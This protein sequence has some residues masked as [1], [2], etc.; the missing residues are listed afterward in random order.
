MDTRLVQ[1]L[2][3]QGENYLIPF[4]WQYGQQEDE[5][6]HEIEKI[7]ETGIRSVCIESRTH[8]DF[9]GDGWWNDMDIIMDEAR[10]RNMRVW[11]LDD[12]RFPTGFAAGKIRDQFPE[13]RKWYLDQRHV[14][15]IGPMRGASVLVNTHLLDGE[16]LVGVVAARNGDKE[17][18][19]E[20]T[21]IN[22]TKNIRSGSLYWDI[23]EGCWRVF[24]LVM[25]R[26][27]GEVKTADYLNPIVPES[28]RVLIDTVYETHYAR[29]KEDFGNT[30]AGFF[31]D[32][33]RFGN[34]FAMDAS[35][36]R[37]LMVLPWRED[38]I[39]ILEKEFGTD[40][41]KYLPCLWYNAGDKTN[42]LR[43]LYMNTV[44]SLYSEHF[45]GQIGNWCRKHKVEYIGHVIEDNNAHAR[46]GA[47][48]GHFFRALWGQDMSGL[49]VVL[50]QIRP[51]FDY[52]FKNVS[53]VANGEFYHYGLAKMASSLGHIDPKKK[54]RTICEI[55]GAY[56]WYEGL[57]LMK[58]LTDHMLVRGVNYFVP[59]A[60]SSKEYP[61]SDCPPHFYANGNNP[62]FRYY[63]ILMSYTN[64]ICHLLNDGTHVAPVAVLYH[65]EAEWSGE[66][67]LFQKPVKEL[68]QHQIDC[69]IIPADIF[70][71][72][73]V[74]LNNEIYINKE[75]YKCLVIPYAESLPE[76]LLYRVHEMMEKGLPV[77]FID[78]LP[79][80][81]SEG[82]TNEE[83]LRSIAG[84]S[85]LEI[86][87]LDQLVD[88]IHSAGIS[89][90]K[91]NKFK[92]YLR[93][94]H[95]QRGEADLYMFFNEDPYGYIETD[96]EIPL[97]GLACEY[98]AFLNK[99]K[100]LQ[101]EKLDN[102][103][104]ISLNLAPYESKII[105][106][107]E[108]EEGT[109][110]LEIDKFQQSNTYVDVSMDYDW[111]VSVAKAKEYPNFKEQFR[112]K[113]L[114]NVSKPEFISGFAG[115]IRYENTFQWNK[116]ENIAILDLGDVYEIAEVWINGKNVGVRICPPYSFDVSEMFFKGENTVIVEV[117][118]TL[119]KEVQ[120]KFS[121]FAQQEPSG[122][123][124]PVRIRI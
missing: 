112:L 9:G 58:W 103:T 55:F 73:L 42:S 15:V 53:R 40:I 18:N 90:I 74:I 44:A 24:I 10:R 30:F 124:G 45:C 122:L 87:C 70:K 25:T 68:M 119:V 28:V 48:T 61:D 97:E 8:P 41:I 80:G 1:L 77:Y 83:I 20:G 17:G 116:E 11:V 37:S 82:N 31:S 120:D 13:L 89:E 79:D 46:L 107:D 59:H 65:A 5:L 106:F 91:V 50:Q 94:Y 66:Y 96:V 99:L 56:G 22:L 57:K 33:P 64:R 54:G 105:I 75:K 114:V 67:M 109:E 36:G 111:K 102:G 7:N 43:Y 101:I 4:F 27:G 35:I 92:P 88:K 12:A 86:V 47:G 26:N 3:G 85:N 34:L 6:R 62:Q 104:R 16:R 63:G 76:F 81:V 69:D 38:M 14:D 32:E 23:P 49:D 113:E 19:L 123:L 98:D 84:N 78:K 117:T 71:D 100:K 108:K 52:D 21:M 121:K 29:Y 95:Y 60:F 118:N 93:Y 2:Q 72:Q 51:G 39:E 110:S 115:T